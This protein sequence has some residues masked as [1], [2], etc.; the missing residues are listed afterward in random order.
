MLVDDLFRLW[1]GY[2]LIFGECGGCAW[3]CV[4]DCD[5]HD[6][7]VC[8][9][10]NQCC[11]SQEF[12]K[13]VKIKRTCPTSHRHCTGWYWRRIVLTWYRPKGTHWIQ[14]LVKKKKRY[15]FFSQMQ[16]NTLLLHIVIYISFGMLHSYKRY[17]RTIVQTW[18]AFKCS[19]FVSRFIFNY[20]YPLITWW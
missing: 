19:Q 1:P 14:P 4:P 7:H 5:T 15:F 2:S 9:N 8:N 20:F 10:R 12:H 13:Q 18:T 17:A 6:S 16:K 11:A 3:L